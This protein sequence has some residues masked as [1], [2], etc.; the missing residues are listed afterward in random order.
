VQNDSPSID[1]SSWGTAARRFVRAARSGVLSTV[2]ASRAGYPFGSIVT[3]VPDA[4]ARPV[5]LI[6]RLAEHSANLEADGRSSLLVQQPGDDAQ[7]LTR[8]TLIC[9]A[10]PLEADRA[11]ADR[12]VR[13]LPSAA[14]LLALGDFHF[15]TL[16]PRAARYI[17]GFGAIRWVES[18]DY[19]PAWC[20][21]PATE[22]ALIGR[23]RDAFL[24]AV[25]RRQPSPA[26]GMQ[27]AL[28][29]LGFD[30]DGMDITSDGK[31]ARIEWPQPA[32]GAAQLVEQLRSGR[33]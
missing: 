15:M 14:R 25:A 6:S 1:R 13:Q 2:S 21:D 17:A 7:A 18:G 27:S 4:E 12:F 3:F 20:V 8:V 9:D 29:V 16:R 22:Q 33:L 5:I 11:F 26:G 23:N 31:A 32:A 24:R 30:S 28:E 19:L 10:E